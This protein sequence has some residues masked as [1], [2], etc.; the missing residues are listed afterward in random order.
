M[1]CKFCGFERLDMGREKEDDVG[2]TCFLVY[3]VNFIM[4]CE[5]VSL[6]FLLA[7]AEIS[8]FCFFFLIFF[9]Y[10]F[11]FSSLFFL[12]FCWR[13]KVQ[14]RKVKRATLLCRALLNNQGIKFSLWGFQCW[15]VYGDFVAPLYDCLTYLMVSSYD[16]SMEPAKISC[17]VRTIKAINEFSL[18][19]VYIT[20]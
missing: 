3:D 12:F 7:P 1:M 19:W 16:D 11:L 5:F 9:F 14:K 6:K 2:F 17:W 13:N 10:P 4:S 20:Q 18:G 15:V 8:T